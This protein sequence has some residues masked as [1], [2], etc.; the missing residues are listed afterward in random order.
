M[1]RVAKVLKAVGARLKRD[2]KHL[3]YELPN[4]RNVVLPKTPSDWRSELNCV[5]DIRKAAGVARS[6][7][8]AT[9]PRERKAKPGRLDSRSWTVAP[10]P[11]AAALQ[12]SG[13]AD[14]AK[15]ADLEQKV[16]DLRRTVFAR[17]A[18]I[19]ELEASWPVRAAAWV[20]SLWTKTGT[21]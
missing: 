20:R 11:L 5:S 21:E 18:R 4:G 3:V 15:I 12:Q 10:N 2:R 13:V 14:A 17:E 9:E 19:A 6:P 7:K 16:A 1:T 8:A